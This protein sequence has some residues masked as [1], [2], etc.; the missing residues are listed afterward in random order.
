M[1]S[2]RRFY[3]RT[4]TADDHNRLDALVGAID[5]AASYRN[6]LSGM[7]GFRAPLERRLANSALPERWLPWR[8]LFLGGALATDLESLGIDLPL[9]HDATDGIETTAALIGTLY[10]LEGASL[11]GQ[12]IAR[13]AAA[14]GIGAGNGA[15]HLNPAGDPAGNWRGFLGVLENEPDLDMDAV[16][17]ASR[18][19]FTLARQSFE[20]YCV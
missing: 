8:P 15:S 5:G 13:R 10:T 3:L 16:A 11:G 9:A 19:A 12:L 1:A 7:Y 2:T 14:I 6:Y 20:R 17:E 4:S 18:Q